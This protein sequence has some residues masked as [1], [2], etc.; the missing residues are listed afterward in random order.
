MDVVDGSSLESAIR[1]QKGQ[2]FPESQIVDWLRK[3]CLALRHL[4]SHNIVHKDL[5]PIK[6]LLTKTG[7]LKIG[8]LGLDL[9]SK[10]M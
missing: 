5:R 2:H 9:I 4:H 6:F 7:E 10:D 1:E 3:T 8:E